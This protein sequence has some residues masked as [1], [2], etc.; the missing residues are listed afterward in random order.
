MQRFHSQR[1]GLLL[2]R[3]TLRVPAC[4]N[5][6]RIPRRELLL[7][8]KKTGH[9]EIEQAPQF[10]H[11]VLNRSSAQDQSVVRRQ[12][13]YRDARARLA[14][15]YYVTLVEDDVVPLH[16]REETDVFPD[17]VVRG[18]NDVVSLEFQTEFLALYRGS[19]VL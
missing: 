10:E 16:G 7:C 17:D 5:R 8:P 3:G 12:V 11:I 15:L 2:F 4:Q 9:E 6:S 14:V 1:S 18:D 19:V 13:L